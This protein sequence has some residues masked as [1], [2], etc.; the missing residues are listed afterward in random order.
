MWCLRWFG[1]FVQLGICQF[2]EQDDS[3]GLFWWIAC[4]ACGRWSNDRDEAKWKLEAKL[5]LAAPPICN[6]T[7]Q[8]HEQCIAHTN[9]NTNTRSPT[10]NSPN[11]T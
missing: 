4:G 7:K 5:D 8:T 11:Q 9:V 10:D 1:G 3:I 2:I 6:S